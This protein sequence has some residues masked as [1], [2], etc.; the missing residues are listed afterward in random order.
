[1][2]NCIILILEVWRK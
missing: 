1:M 2:K